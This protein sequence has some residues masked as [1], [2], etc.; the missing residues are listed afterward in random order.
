MLLRNLLQLGTAADGGWCCRHGKAAAVDRPRGLQTKV[1]T[2][3]LLFTCAV[4][5]PAVDS[6]PIDIAACCMLLTKP[7][8]G[9]RERLGL[10]RHL[11]VIT[12][13]T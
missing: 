9:S 4:S 8:A 12:S 10:V 6:S 3:E 13:G 5:M 11:A 2:F 7:V 1:S